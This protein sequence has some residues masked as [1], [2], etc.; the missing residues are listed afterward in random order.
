MRNWRDDK[1][2]V[3]ESVYKRRFAFLP[4]LCSS[5]DKQIWL[6]WY[7]KKYNVWNSDIYMNEF[8]HVDYAESINEEEFMFRKLSGTL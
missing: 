6:K 2:M 1:G 8:D 7:Y 5:S 3:C 4:V